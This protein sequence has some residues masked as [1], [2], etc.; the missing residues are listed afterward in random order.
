MKLTFLKGVALGSVVAVATLSATSAM[1][2]TGIGAVFNLGKTNKVNATSSLTGRASGTMLAVT[3][4]GSGPALGL[5]V[6]KGTAPFKVNSRTEVTNLNAGLLGGLASANFVKGGGD[7]HAFAVTMTAGQP[8][9]MLL[10]IPG[11]G[12]LQAS[13]TMAG[14]EITYENGSNAVDLWHFAATAPS[15][16]GFGTELVSLPASTNHGLFGASAGDTTWGSVIIDY[17]SNSGLVP[18][19]HVATVNG[20]VDFGNGSTCKFVAQELAGAGR[21]LP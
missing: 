11:Y 3:N 6:G 2:G 9:E 21:V 7:A 14:G 5:S 20:G 12:R 15:M 13:C 4:K 1:A 10:S 16:Q 8:A 19:Q 17:E 18:V